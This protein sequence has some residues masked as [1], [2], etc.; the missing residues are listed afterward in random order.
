MTLPTNL[1][2]QGSLKRKGHHCF[3]RQNMDI[4]VYPAPAGFVSLR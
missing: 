2:Q 4:E 3:E 1:L